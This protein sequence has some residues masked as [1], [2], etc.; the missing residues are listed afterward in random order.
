[1]KLADLI[2][3][4]PV[5]ISEIAKKADVSRPT[6]YKAMKGEKVTILSIKKLCAYFKVDFKDY[7]T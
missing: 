5:S 1:M 2:I 6:V 4:A 3:N 7:L